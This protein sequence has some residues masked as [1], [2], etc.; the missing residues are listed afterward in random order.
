MQRTYFYPSFSRAKLVGLLFIGGVIGSIITGS[1]VWLVADPPSGPFVH[2]QFVRPI[3]FCTAAVDE[4][5]LRQLIRATEAGPGSGTNK[6]V[7]DGKAIVLS[8]EDEL[9]VTKPGPKYSHVSIIGGEHDS[10][11][12]I[13]NN[14]LLAIDNR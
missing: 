13:V 10:K 1:I 11:I 5:S 3:Q 2:G 4:Q 7:E 9:H 8:P 12:V 14:A 6:L